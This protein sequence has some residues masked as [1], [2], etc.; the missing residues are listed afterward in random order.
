M[1]FT[2]EQIKKAM[3]CKSEAELVALAKSE[4]IDLTEEEAGKFFAS[5]SEKKINLNELEGV[6]GGACYGNVCGADC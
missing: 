5:M 1:N 3:G 2:Q 6:Q 4:G